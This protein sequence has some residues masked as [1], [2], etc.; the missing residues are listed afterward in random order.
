M[1]KKRKRESCYSYRARLDYGAS[2][3]ISQQSLL[4]EIEGLHGLVTEKGRPPGVPLSDQE[5]GSLAF[6]R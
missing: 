4:R 1:L 6:Q 3:V 2:G 5:E